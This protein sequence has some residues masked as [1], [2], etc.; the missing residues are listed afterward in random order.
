M[1]L[2]NSAG[3]ITIT[4]PT[5]ASVSFPVGTEIEL[6]RQGAG[7]VTV[8]AASGVTLLSV[9]SQVA[10]AAQYGVVALKQI[11]VDTWLLAG[12]LG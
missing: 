4:I 2:C 10:I 3:A 7:T 8:V 6:C 9:D 12:A 1:Q 5:N 11:A